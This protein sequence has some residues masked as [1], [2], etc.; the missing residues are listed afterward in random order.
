MSNSFRFWPSSAPFTNVWKRRR[1]RHPLGANETLP[2]N[3]LELRSRRQ[4][5]G[6]LDG[7]WRNSRGRLLKGWV[8]LLVDHRKKHNRCVRAVC[9]KPFAYFAFVSTGKRRR[10][11]ERPAQNWCK[12]GRIDSPLH[13][14]K[15]MHSSHLGRAECAAFRYALHLCHESGIVLRHGRI[16]TKDGMAPPNFGSCVDPKSLVILCWVPKEGE[17]MVRLGEQSVKVKRLHFLCGRK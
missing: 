10:R 5:G 15:E 13:R 7:R 3:Q 4:K 8:C 14:A 11:V 9:W 17:K 16:G 12:S 1:C 2:S 6:T